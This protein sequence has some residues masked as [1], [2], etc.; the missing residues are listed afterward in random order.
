[1]A[2]PRNDLKT[3]PT[4]IA[5]TDMQR[6]YLAELVKT[7]LYGKN[8]ADAAERLVAGGLERLVKEGTIRLLQK[9]GART[10]KNRPKTK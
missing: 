10:T 5:T 7:G 4:T 6:A 3:V 8:S 9:E 2:R 1:M